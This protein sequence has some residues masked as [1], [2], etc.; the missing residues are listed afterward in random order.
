MKNTMAARV[1]AKH[2]AA[3]ARSTTLSP[4][5]MMAGDGEDKGY[6]V[7]VVNANPVQGGNYWVEGY[8]RKGDAYSNNWA[9]FHTYFPPPKTKK[10]Q[11]LFERGGLLIEKGRE[12]RV[13]RILKEKGAP[14]P[15]ARGDVSR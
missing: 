14:P 2:L 8:L 1:A 15:D 10:L 7:N 3:G 12:E 6:F 9:L 13:T 11:P 4:G 5:A